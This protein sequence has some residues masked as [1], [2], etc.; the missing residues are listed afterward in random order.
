MQGEVIA[1]GGDEQRRARVSIRRQHALVRNPHR[2]DEIWFDALDITTQSVGGAANGEGTEPLSD[3][4]AQAHGPGR[5]GA[6]ALSR[7]FD[8]AKCHG[9]NL[10]SLNREVQ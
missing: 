3:S 7:F 1:P 8:G 2:M 9:R 6:G 4:G 5:G 10:E